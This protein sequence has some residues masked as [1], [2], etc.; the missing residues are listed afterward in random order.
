MATGGGASLAK[1]KDSD[2]DEDEDEDDGSPFPFALDD[3]AFSEDGDS[4]AVLVAVVVAVD[5]GRPVPVVSDTDGSV[6]TEVSPFIT[7]SI[8]TCSV[9]TDGAAGAAG[10]DKDVEVNG[11]VEEEE[12]EETEGGCSAGGGRYISGMFAPVRAGQAVPLPASEVETVEETGSCTASGRWDGGG[13]CMRRGSS[14]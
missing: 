4:V 1:A 8:F 2:E 9:L 6:L 11:V 10:D 13:R 7:C 12:E 14:E 3:S 5:R